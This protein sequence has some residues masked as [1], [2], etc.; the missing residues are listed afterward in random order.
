MDNLI[1]KPDIYEGGDPY[2]FISFHQNDREK[3]LKILEKLDLRGFRFWIDD[4]IA[5]GMET[6]EII[7]QHIENCDFFIAF[8]SE[9]YLSFLDKVDELNYSRDENKDYLLVY[10]EDLSLPYGL[11]MRFMRSQSI[12]AFTMNDQEIYS[13]LLNIDG[14]DKFYGV[15]DPKLRLRA[16]TIF[17]KLEKFYPDHKVF[18]LDAVNKQISKEI[19]E[20]YIKAGYPNAERLMADYG[21][22]Q[23]SS[24]DARNLRSSV[25]YQPGFEPD[26]IKSRIDYIVKTLET[27]YPDKN[28]T[29]NLSKTHHAIYA[30][31]LGISIWMG[32]D[33]ISDML[34]A[35]GFSVTFFDAGRKE[36]DSHA[37]IAQ[38]H[39]KYREKNKPTSL[40]QLILENK[41][42]HGNLK[43]LI[44]RSTSLFG[45]TFSQYLKM[46]NL[47]V[48][49]EKK[50]KTDLSQR[51]RTEIFEEIQTRYQNADP[52]YGTYEETQDTL[53]S[54]VLKKAK[55][56]M[57]R[58]TKCSF[59]NETVRIPYGIDCI[60]REA[61]CG[62]SDLKTLILPP[63]VKEIRESA[64]FDCTDLETIV[65]SNGLEYIADN[66]FAG[67]TS[68]KKVEFPESLKN[69]GNEAFSE[70]EALAN[71]TFANP[72][73]NIREDAFDGCI[74]QLKDLRDDGASPAEYFELKVD[75]KNNAKIIS[76]TGDEEIV[77]I[78]GMIGGHPILSIEKGCFKANHRITEVYISDQI[79]A[80]NG[81]VFKDCVNLKKVHISNAVATFTAT[82][83]SGCTNLC[84]INIPDKMEEVKQNLFKDSPITT[85]YIGKGTKKISTDA[86]YKGKPDIGTGLWFK[87]KSLETLIIDSGNPYF[88]ADGT[89]LFSADG[90]I[91]FAEMGDPLEATV[92]QGT[93]EIADMAYDRLGSLCKITF[94]SSL[95][96][97]GEKAFQNTNL[98]SVELPSSLKIIGAQAFSYCR[99]L[100]ALDINEGLR[101]IGAQA[102]EGCPIKDVY[103]P[104]TVE[105]IGINSFFSISAYPGEIIQTFRIDTANPYLIADG[106][107]LY[108]K[109]E[110]ALKLIKAYEHSLK[111]KPS[112]EN[113][114]PIH[115]DI[116]EGTTEISPHAFAMCHNLKSVSIPESVRCIGDMA[117]WDCTQLTNIHIPENC[118]QVSSNAFFGTNACFI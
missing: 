23:I 66:A 89:A 102:F 65:F 21:F 1:Y 60:D 30:S 26:F 93:E 106:I 27:D 28:I 80:L 44:N 57:I 11:D 13:Q 116:M 91:L 99:K 64:F 88:K 25:L 114:E 73:S 19:S 63:T 4:G 67:C 48:S 18:A 69:I 83:F 16:E 53:N 55:S 14:A 103:I 74:Y 79:S 95:K 86:F 70:C 56:G 96:K 112:E 94:P 20:L 90:K 43:T 109:S 33:S 107:A 24:E 9:N 29:E 87:K 45:M 3:V 98:Q 54:L 6:D 72:R 77:V 38:L 61:F 5:P 78:P 68:L 31:L 118:T 97:I 62:M 108:E 105:S 85:L 117:F 52:S 7:A 104:S 71:V 8:L 15:S 22:W 47:I 75:K 37:I 76:Y 12:K 42:I 58:V 49:A 81:D 110:H 10:L 35:Y 41:D 32:Y 46:E 2:I 113:Q 51:R 59:C 111:R 84:E 82:A 115:Y 101:S 36:L 100:S 34:R 92:P 50:E 39:E 17:N 40:T